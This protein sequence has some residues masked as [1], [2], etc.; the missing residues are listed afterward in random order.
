[1]QMVRQVQSEVILPLCLQGCRDEGWEA[2]GEEPRP[3]W[4][5]ARSWRDR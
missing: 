1:M 3:R 4:P 2:E 5:E